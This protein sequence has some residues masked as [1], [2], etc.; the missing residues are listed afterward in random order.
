[1]IGGGKK[2][3]EDSARLEAYLTAAFGSLTTNYVNNL[4]PGNVTLLIGDV[5]PL[6]STGKISNSKYSPP[7]HFHSLRA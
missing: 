5:T 3:E 2:T 7:I 4:T 6:I 1:M